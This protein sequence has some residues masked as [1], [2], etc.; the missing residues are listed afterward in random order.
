MLTL[1]EL[2]R[3]NQAVPH[4]GCVGVRSTCVTGGQRTLAAS[5]TRMQRA[6]PC[7]KTARYAT[8]QMLLV[9]KIAGESR[10]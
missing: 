7:S 10:L 5:T 9:F 2:S 1:S 4:A 8:E 6:V 3:P